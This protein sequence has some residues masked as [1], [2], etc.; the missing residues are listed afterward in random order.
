[1]VNM[2]NNQNNNNTPRMVNQERLQ[3]ITINSVPYKRNN[4]HEP[5]QIQQ[6][7]V[8]NSKIVHQNKEI[9]VM[10]L[11]HSV[12]F[13]NQN[14]TPTGFQHPHGRPEVHFSLINPPVHNWSDTPIFLYQ[15]F[16]LIHINKFHKILIPRKKMDYEKYLSDKILNYRQ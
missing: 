12:H 10:N 7:H 5:N 15:Q 13:H 6:H 2:P 8:N 11:G 9:P 16:M 14:L 1:M 3:M 4:E